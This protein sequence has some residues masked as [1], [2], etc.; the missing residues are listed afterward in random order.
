MCGCG[1]TIFEAKMSENHS[2]KNKNNVM[3][4]SWQVGLRKV[5]QTYIHAKGD[6]SDK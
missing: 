1:R 3:C 5:I 2:K 6:K 4:G